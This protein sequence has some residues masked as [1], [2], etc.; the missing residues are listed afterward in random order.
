MRLKRN[1]LK[2]ISALLLCAMLCGCSAE[3]PAPEPSP[4][5]KATPG[6]L[7]AQAG[8]IDACV[9]FDRYVRLFPDPQGLGKTIF[10]FSIDT[11][12]IFIE[13]G[14]AAS[15]KINSFM[16]ALDEQ[17]VPGE[18]GSSTQMDAMTYYLSLAED[19]YTA[20]AGTE[21]EDECS[22]SYVRTARVLRCDSL[23]TEFEYSLYI[24]SAEGASQERTVYAFDSATGEPLPPESVTE[25][26][27]PPYEAP[28]EGYLGV[29][30]MDD[31]LTDGIGVED[32]IEADE[33]G[34]DYLVR[35]IGTVDGLEINE[36]FY[37]AD[38]TAYTTGRCLYYRTRL[39]DE[40]V[41]LRYEIPEGTPDLE[42]RFNMHGRSVGN[43]LTYDAQTGAIALKN[44]ENTD[45]SG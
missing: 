16:Q 38:R 37:S 42:L 34:R 2:L 5:P 3:R 39:T 6:P 19:C 45:I 28:G 18:N 35:A 20:F 21:K 4:V 1:S 22:F 44:T 10:T 25:E 17:I 8:P 7:K 29:F 12:V 33:N 9:H 14:E 40:G 24:S 15:E 32:M 13:G 41:Q 30:Q 36:I 23:V 43:V 26:N 31:Y 11:P 27:F